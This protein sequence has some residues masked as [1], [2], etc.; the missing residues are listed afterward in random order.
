[1]SKNQ[2]MRWTVLGK[3]SRG[4]FSLCECACGTRRDVNNRNLR[5]GLSKS[6]GCARPDGRRRH[7][8]TGSVEFKIWVGM[9]TRCYNPDANGYHNYGALGV[10]LCDRWLGEQGFVNFL[11]DMGPRPTPEHSIDRY[12]NKNGNY[13]PGN[14]RWATRKDQMRNV[15]YNRIVTAEGRDQCVAGWAEELGVKYSRLYALL[16]KYGDEEAVRRCRNK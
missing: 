10:V 16:I 15:K 6:C 9:K 11:A 5:A 8:L 14:C 4:G 2:S 7:G 1:M 12:P 13:E 3:G